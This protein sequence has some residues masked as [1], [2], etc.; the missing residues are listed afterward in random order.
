MTLSE[1]PTP[2]LQIARTQRP[3]SYT[4]IIARTR[5]DATA[6]LRDMRRELLALDPNLVFIENQTMEVRG[7]C[8]AVPDARERAGW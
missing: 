6:L 1:P 4:A 3:S 8:D 5:G 2:F 7:G